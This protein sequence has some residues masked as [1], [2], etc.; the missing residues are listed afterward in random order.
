MSA[1]HI[2]VAG[3]FAEKYSKGGQYQH[4]L[5]FP[6]RVTKAEAKQQM[7]STSKYFED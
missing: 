3:N 7:M 1:N 4:Q 5:A 2:F 6:R